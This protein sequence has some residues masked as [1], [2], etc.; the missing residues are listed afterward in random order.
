MAKKNQI[1]CYQELGIAGGFWSTEKISPKKISETIII[2]IKTSGGK[3]L[4]PI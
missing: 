2:A 1:F 4:Q 3:E